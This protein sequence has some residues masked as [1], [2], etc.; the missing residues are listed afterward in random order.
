[1]EK[2]ILYNWKRIAI[3]ELSN[4]RASNHLPNNCISFE[5]MISKS[6]FNAYTTIHT[7]IESLQNFQS[8]IAKLLK[9]NSYHVVFVSSDNALRIELNDD[10]AGH[11]YQK[12]E[13]KADEMNCL[14]INDYFDKT[15]LPELINDINSI[16]A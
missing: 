5:T 3:M 6:I 12:I 14:T 8:D 13:L 7:S 2:V 10:P 9:Q 1:M 11:V 15:F 4:F 16:I